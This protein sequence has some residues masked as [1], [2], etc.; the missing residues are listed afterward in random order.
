MHPG[1]LRA[2]VE[3]RRAAARRGEAPLASTYKKMYDTREDMDWPGAF[4]R[5][6]LSM[7]FSNLGFLGQIALF[8]RCLRGAAPPPLALPYPFRKCP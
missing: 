6:G 8:E 2:H 3:Q 5:V 1:K 4:D 7:G